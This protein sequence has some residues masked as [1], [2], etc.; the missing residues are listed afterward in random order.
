MKMNH[1]IV[2]AMILGSLTAEQLFNAANGQPVT[3]IEEITR[4]NSGPDEPSAWAKILLPPN[5]HV[6]IN[7]GFVDA[8]KAVKPKKLNL[9]AGPGENYSVLG[10]LQQGD[11]VTQLSAKGD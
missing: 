3:V 10:Q 9:R 8:N 1:L 11:N 6:W 7:G 4:T 2:F 5:A